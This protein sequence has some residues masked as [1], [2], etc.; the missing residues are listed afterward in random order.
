MRADDDRQTQSA[1]IPVNRGPIKRAR[2]PSSERGGRRFKSCHSDQQTKY[3]AD[4][5]ILAPKKLPKETLWGASD[6][7]PF[8]SGGQDSKYWRPS[9]RD[10]QTSRRFSPR[11]RGWVHGGP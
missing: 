11:R 8:A 7:C 9:Y 6:N 1:S 3:L 5:P 2:T 4:S 10:P